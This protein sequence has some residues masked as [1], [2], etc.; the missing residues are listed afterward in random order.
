MRRILLATLLWAAQLGGCGRADDEAA[1]RADP[2]T[3]SPPDTAKDDELADAPKPPVATAAQPLA[4]DPPPTPRRGEAIEFAAGKLVL[5]SSPVTPHRNAAVE[6]D[7]VSVDVGAFSIDRLPYPNDPDAVSKTGVTRPE[8]AKLCAD[9]G[10]RLCTEAEWER[11]CKADAGHVYPTGA[12]LDLTACIAAGPR[13][14]NALGMMSMGI[15]AREWTASEWPQGFGNPMRTAVTRGAA[16]DAEVSAHRCSA[17][18]G[19]TAD[20]ASDMIGFRCCQG[21]GDNARFSYPTEPRRRVVAPLE[22]KVKALRAALAT[23]PKLAP[24]ADAFKP[25]GGVD[26]ARALA[27]GKR[28]RGSI[29]AWH[30]ADSSFIWSPGPGQALWV[31]S[32]FSGERSVVAAFHSMPDGSLLHAASTVIDEPDTSV[33]LGYTEDKPASLLW[34]TC[35]GCAGEGGDLTVREDGVVGFTYR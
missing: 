4:T 14:G 24:L 18:S 34:T 21:S 13:C 23:H 2:E 5:G 3:A 11:A 16:A 25:F 19:A 31:F 8:A 28:S 22:V 9:D 6:A 12:A 10:K 1:P 15:G 27:R 30:I 20:S 35:F 7:L 33:A 29:T 26:I 32:G 17:R